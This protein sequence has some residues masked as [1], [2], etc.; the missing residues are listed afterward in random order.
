MYVAG[1]AES[2]PDVGPQLQSIDGF[3]NARLCM[4]WNLKQGNGFRASVVAL[5]V[6]L[7]SPQE[8]DTRLPTNHKFIITLHDLEEQS[9]IF[10]SFIILYSKPGY[11]AHRGIYKVSTFP[12]KSREKNTIQCNTKH[13][14]KNDSSITTFG[15]ICCSAS[16]Y[17]QNCLPSSAYSNQ[18]HL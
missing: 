2:V 10:L 5:L 14:S 8:I 7:L 6:I 11:T 9:T 4:R 3:A 17:L 15:S 13:F 18:S 16:C 1:R 12:S